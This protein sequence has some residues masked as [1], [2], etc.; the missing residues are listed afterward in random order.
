MPIRITSFLYIESWR[1]NFGHYLHFFE[2]GNFPQITLDGSIRL[3]VVQNP[4]VF[5]FRPE[6]A[7]A[8]SDPVRSFLGAVG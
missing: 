8:G 2:A 1:A 4:N 7:S 6:T 5:F 3:L